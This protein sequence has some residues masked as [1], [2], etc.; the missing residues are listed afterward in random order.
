M[1]LFA[2]RYEIIKGLGHGATGSVELAVDT[3]TGMKSAL[4]ILRASGTLN[5]GLALEGFKQEF[6]ILKEINHPNIAKVFDAGFDQES[7]QFFISTEYVPAKDLYS[8][9][10]GLSFEETEDIFVQTLRALNYL[11]YRHIYHLDIKPRN[12]LVIN[13]DNRFIV[14][15]IDFGY[16]NFFDSQY[17]KRKKE[18]DKDHIIIVGS[19]AYTAPEIISGSGHD[20]RTDLYSL[21]CVFYEALTRWLPFRADSKNPDEVHLKHLHETPAPPKGVNKNIPDYFNNIILRLM[22]KNP[23]DRFALA[24]DVIKEINFFKDKPYDI[25]TQETRRSYLLERSKLIGRDEE[26]KK[27]RKYYEDRILTEEYQKSPC[28]VIRGERG[29]GKS[30]L[31][32]EFKQEAQRKFDINILTWDEFNK[33]LMENLKTPCL[34]IG[35]DVQL[36]KLHLSKL[37]YGYKQRQILV[38][39]TTS[40]KEIPCEEENIIKL[41]YFTKEELVEYLNNTIGIK[42]IPDNIID[43]LYKYTNHGCPLYLVQFLKAAF[44]SSYLIDSHGRWSSRVFNDLVGRLKTTGFTDFIKKDLLSKVDTLTLNESQLDLIYTMALTDKPTLVDIKEMTG[45]HLIEEQLEYFVEKGILKTDPEDRFVFSN[46]LYK[47]IFTERMP[48]EVKEEYCDQ[49]ADYYEMQNESEEK[50]L[51]FRGRGAGD[52]SGEQLFKL[53]QLTRKE[54]LFEEAIENLL[55][56]TKKD[57]VDKELMANAHLML[58]EIYIEKGQYDEARL[59]LNKIIN[60]KV[61]DGD[62]LTA[63]AYEQKGICFYRKKL[64]SESTGCYLKSLAILGNNNDYGWM[65]AGLKNRMAINEIEMGNN[66]KSEQLSEEAW[67]IWN[68]LICKK[69]GDKHSIVE[70]EIIHFNKGEYSKA[71]DSLNQQ[72]EGLKNR[73]HLELYPITVYRL[74]VIKIKMG[75]T[76]EGEILLNECINLV[77]E[78]QTPNWLF[79]VYNELGVIAEK[80]NDYKKA[81]EYYQHSFDLAEKTSLEEINAYIAAFN[82]ARTY[83]ALNRPE[84]SKNHF[85]YIINN[86]EKFKDNKSV[87]KDF[88]VIATHIELAKILRKQGDFDEAHVVLERALSII[89]GKEHFK[90]YEQFYLQEKAL[91]CLSNKYMSDFK[92]IEKELECLKKESWFDK[93]EFEFWI[94]TKDQICCST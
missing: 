56:I 47:E 43:D 36:K 72:L 23:D 89:K 79:W 77:K 60:N 85:N 55:E 26:L 51:Y 54:L 91:I 7:S 88:I 44:A 64:Y 52:N 74:G 49:I 48:K 34:V 75:Y 53:A 62:I 63:R 13:E 12:I 38:V 42:D 37:N 6:E 69:E 25:E 16:A 50:I 19:P 5:R 32:R 94:K 45:G 82:L 90:V 73:Q 78:R 57:K 87:N 61:G 81:S 39:L 11:H 14:K 70:R 15:I 84:D 8:V 93:A 4:K 59:C 92:N 21:G 40:Q 10:E 20:G 2:D 41:S 68:A 9:T 86:V 71:I 67:A 17:A 83:V 58:G 29:S 18:E 46:P 66:D 1:G 35:D 33:T 27:F 22:Q 24:E 3:K 76:D 80:R 65:A 30:R 28:L 31:L